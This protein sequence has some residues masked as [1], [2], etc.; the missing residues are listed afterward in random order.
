[1]G[2]VANYA[3]NLAAL[4]LG[5]EPCRPL[6]FS[7]YITHRCAFTCTYCSDGAG[8]PFKQSSVADLPTAEA[9]AL[10]SILR[11]DCDTL[12]ITGGEPLERTDL[13][14]VLQYAKNLRFRTVLNTKGVGLRQRPRL[15]ALCDVVVLSLDSL[16]RFLLTGLTGRAPEITGEMIA[17]VR[18]VIET[19]RQTKTKVALAA[20]VTPENIRAVD[21]VFQF[22]V[23]NKLA[24]QL[25]P[26][27]VGTR[28]HDA[29]RSDPR[30]RELVECLLRSK[31]AGAR[32]LGVPGYLR[33]IR[34]FSS[35]R[36]HPL[37]MPTIR[38][39]GRLYYPCLES[40]Q[41]EISILEAGG[42]GAALRQSAERFGWLPACA[43]G[44]QIFC[45]MALSMLQRS[46]AAALSELKAW[47]N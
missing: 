15:I 37:L 27:V 29:L 38:P 11:R 6:L 19:A 44:C 9:K 3:R 47:R 39:D 24:F 14:D 35:F 17:T 34:D 18:F 40:G 32:V 43:D 7:Y 45:H 2:F 5:R 25:S 36:C 46:P 8:S 20:V 16:D 10:I 12:D 4:V 42:Y 13:E 21:D 26:Q 30:Y 33:G 41:A 28:A 23:D 22:A 31:A 1:M